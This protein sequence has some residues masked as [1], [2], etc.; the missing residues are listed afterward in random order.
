MER[1]SITSPSRKFNCW[2]RASGLSFFCEILSSIRFLFCISDLFCI[3][4][5]LTYK[6]SNL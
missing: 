1:A 6:A 4:V 5:M 2:G 3:F